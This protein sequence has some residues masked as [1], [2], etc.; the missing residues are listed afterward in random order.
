MKLDKEVIHENKKMTL[1][2]LI[3][4]G[5]VMVGF[6]V[7]KQFDYTVALGGLVG[8]LL[9]IGNFFFMSIGVVK[10]LETGDESSAKLK[11]RSSYIGRTVVMIAVMAVSLVVDWMH[12]LPVVASVFYPR[13]V[14][15]ANNLLSLAKSRKKHLAGEDSEEGS[16]TEKIS[17]QSSREEPESDEEDALD[18]FMKGFY[19]GVVPGEEKSSGNERR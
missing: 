19:K 4:T 9:A 12:W 14:I 11:M 1:G 5:L 2:C 6:L 13:I 10:A 8:W 18:S 7:A 17:E 15:T 3:C 16:A